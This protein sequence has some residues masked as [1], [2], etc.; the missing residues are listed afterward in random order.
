MTILAG[1]ALFM[2]GYVVGHR[3]VSDPGTAVSDAQAF[4][5][6][7]D[8]YHTIEQRYAGGE[9]DRDALIQGAIK[10][11]IDALGDPYSSYL[12]S[13]EYR[14]TL[15]GLSG[16]FEGIGANIATEA[17]D[18]TQGCPTLGADCHLLI[19]SP[20]TGSP[21][22]KAGIKPGDRVLARRWRVARWPDGGRCP[23]QDP[24]PEG[25]GR[26]VDDP[27]W[28]QHAD[29]SR[30]HARHRAGTGGRLRTTPMAR[31]GMSG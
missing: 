19:T 31:W 4:Q 6:F 14:D 20:V 24:R 8:T 7:W 26:D 3:A 22:E 18:G 13:K 30:D 16:Q 5:P 25:L 2:S 10:G 9:V 21:A 29:R 15:Q 12:T 17:T 27:A 23:R 11:M 1:G 28:R